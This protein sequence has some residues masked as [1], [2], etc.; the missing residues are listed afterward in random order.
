MQISSVFK[1]QFFFKSLYLLFPHLNVAKRHR[2]NAEFVKEKA[3]DWQHFNYMCF[4]PAI[5]MSDKS[6]KSET[7][8]VI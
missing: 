2:H 4:N 7:G 8:T 6:W 1:I 3:S 5:V